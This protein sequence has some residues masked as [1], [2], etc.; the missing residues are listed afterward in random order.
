MGVT[1]R[2]LCTVLPD[3]ARGRRYGSLHHTDVA[4]RLLDHSCCRCTDYA[5]RADRV[6]GCVVLSPDNVTALSWLPPTCAY[7]LLAEGR[8]LYWWHPLVSGDPETVHYAAVSVRGRVIGEDDIP[9]AELEDR[10]VD[11]P[12][13]APSQR[14]SGNGR[15]QTRRSRSRTGAVLAARRE[16]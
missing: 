14:L 3:Q 2:R 13:R 1:V 4:C 9:E 15:P 5:N 7:R 6:A 10:V 16:R 8:D 12:A 11:W